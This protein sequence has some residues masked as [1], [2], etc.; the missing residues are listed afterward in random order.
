MYGQALLFI[1]ENAEQILKQNLK[2]NCKL[3]FFAL[4]GHG[5]LKA[6][7]CEELSVYLNTEERRLKAMGI[8]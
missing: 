2:N 8:I 6:V 7:E 4:H 3:S 1:Q 5:I